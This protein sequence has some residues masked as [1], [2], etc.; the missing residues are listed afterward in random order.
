MSLFRSLSGRLLIVTMAVVMLI[1]VAIFVPSVA[2]YRQDYLMERVR[3]AEIAA[4]T[5]LA[6]PDGLVSSELSAEL[7]AKAQ[8][9]NIVVRREGLREM[10]LSSPDLGPVMTTFDLRE[11]TVW[12]LI[13]DALYR[14]GAA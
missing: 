2:R 1:E 3:R 6:A 5:V 10:V 7:I 13:T 8:V 11:P 12:N 4:L 14:I 9:L